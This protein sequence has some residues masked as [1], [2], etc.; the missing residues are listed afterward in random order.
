MIHT[1]SYKIRH[2]RSAPCSSTSHVLR[3]SPLNKSHSNVL[4]TPANTPNN[5]GRENIGDL[6]G[7]QVCP[8][9]ASRTSAS[10][11]APALALQAG[12]E[13]PPPRGL[14]AQGSPFAAGIDNSS[15][16]STPREHPRE[17]IDVS[18]PMPGPVSALRSATGTRVQLSRRAS[19]AR[20]RVAAGE[21]EGDD[22]SSGTMSRDTR[23]LILDLMKRSDGAMGGPTFHAAITEDGEAEEG[24]GLTPRMAK[25][26]DDKV[27]LGN[28]FSP[29]LGPVSLASAGCTLSVPL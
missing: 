16:A 18:R 2:T 17:S 5:G 14:Q 7:R 10:P 25:E 29:Q 4:N 1:S 22:N 13:P 28:L 12:P 20:P 15:T 11:Q 3:V 8:M 6:P 21:G 19:F 24:L 27:S 26:P 9:A 23:S